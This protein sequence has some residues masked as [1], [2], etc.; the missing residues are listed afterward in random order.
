MSCRI[1]D[2]IGAAERIGRIAGV[3]STVVST[4]RDL[5]LIFQN[6]VRTYAD[7]G[8]CGASLVQHDIQL[9]KP[10]DKI[11][12][13]CDDEHNAR[14]RSQ[15]RRLKKAQLCRTFPDACSY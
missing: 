11:H 5:V 8:G 3:P 4:P 15:M 14:H 6:T 13:G 2:L 10:S 12:H 9:N 7:D 1:P